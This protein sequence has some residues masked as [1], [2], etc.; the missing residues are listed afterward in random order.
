M[1]LKAGADTIGKAATDTMGIE[2]FRVFT[3]PIRL[4]S[5]TWLENK[6]MGF[7]REKFKKTW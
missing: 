6:T 1:A 7:N 2:G 4:R 5:Y 3:H